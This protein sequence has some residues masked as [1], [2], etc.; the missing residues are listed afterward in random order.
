MINLIAKHPKEALR[1]LSESDYRQYCGMLI[2]PN[3]KQSPEQAY[4]MG[5][6]WAM[7]NSAFVGFNADKFRSKLH[8]FRSFNDRCLWAV[9]PDVVGDA[10]TTLV[11]FEQWQPE[12]AD[13]GYK[14]AFAAQ[15]GIKD[16]V[17]PWDRFECLFI[18]GD[19]QFKLSQQTADVVREAKQRG[20]WVHMGRVNSL[21][22][23]RYAFSIG[24]DSVDGTSMAKYNKALSF[25]LPAFKSVQHSL[26]SL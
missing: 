20:K 18:G 17:V 5:V 25:L 2:A 19:T 9:A 10:K 13:L 26:W 15:N 11:Q 7:D 3:N 12:I 8:A 1:V 24:C 16:T 21:K 4:A 14:L 22:R 6:V 23:I